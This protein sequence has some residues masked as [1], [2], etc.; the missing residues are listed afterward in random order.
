MSATEQLAKTPLHA[1]HAA[2]GGRM[3]DFAGWSMPVQYS[4]IVEEHNATREAVG[5]F[6]I[7][8]MGRV[9]FDGPDTATFLDSLMTRSV[10]DMEPQQIRYSLMCNEAGGV[11]DDVLVY[12]PVLREEEPTGGFGVVINAGNREKILAWMKSQLGDYSVEIN[13]K[14]T[15][16]SMIAVQ[17][18]KAIELLDPFT[19][20]ELTS[21]RY[22]T[23]QLMSVAGVECFVSRTGYTGEDGCELICDA[24]KIVNVWEQLLASAEN[25][26]GRAVGLAA[27]DTLRLEAG[28]PLYGHELLESINPIEA[29]LGFAINLRDREFVGK[30]AIMKFQQDSNQRVRIGLQLEGRRVPREDCRLL[31]GDEE[32]GVVTSGTFSPTFDHPIAMGYVKPTCAELGSTLDVDIRG[33]QHAATIVPLPFYERGK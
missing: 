3:V 7:S 16:Y 22:Y 12:R 4:S 14:T 8:H 11:L 1:W 9:L 21:M 32:V 30:A 5:L 23:G 17:G 28:M 13:D 2:H 10:A 19:T 20:G 27:R 31:R 24:D 33:Q 26:G 25:V 6:D 29:K 18:P 15:E